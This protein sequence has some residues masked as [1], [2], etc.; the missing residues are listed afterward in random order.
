[1]PLT[2]PNLDDRRYAD[3]VE[4]AR[5]LIPTYAPEWTNHNP[6]DPG[7]TLIEL[8]AWLAE[9]QIYAL[10]RVTDNNVRTF[11]KLLNGKDWQALRDDVGSA[12]RGYPYLGA[13]PA[14]TGTGHFQRR[15]RSTG[16]GG[17]HSCRPRRCL[18]RR[19]ALMDFETEQPGHVSLIVVPRQESELAAAIGTVADY[20]EPRRLLTTFLHVVGPQ[21]VPW[22]FRRRWRHWPTSRNPI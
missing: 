15:F 20:L 21:Y 4:E 9:M 17:R 3:L 5:A 2:L 10:N 13:E 16:V 18:P 14:A 22:I 12:G 8:F 7:I 6:S 19:N 1:M 11:L